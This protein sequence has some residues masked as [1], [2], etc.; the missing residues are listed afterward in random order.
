MICTTTCISYPVPPGLRPCVVSPIVH[1]L[2]LQQLSPQWSPHHLHW[3][4]VSSR[5]VPRCRIGAVWDVKYFELSNIPLPNL[6]DL[7][8]HFSGTVYRLELSH[9]LSKLTRLQSLRLGGAPEHGERQ[10]YPETG[11]WIRTVHVDSVTVGKKPCLPGV[12]TDELIQYC[13]NSCNCR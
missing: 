12:K 7:H 2:V 8:V 11:D 4:Q 9:T 6:E 1:L 10:P 3:Q 13:I 5:A